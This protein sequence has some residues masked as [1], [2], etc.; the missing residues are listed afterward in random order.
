MGDVGDALVASRVPFGHGPGAA[1][2]TGAP[3]VRDVEPWSASAVRRHGARGRTPAPGRRRPRPRRPA[4]QR[5]R[6]LGRFV[7]GLSSAAARHLR[8]SALS[9]GK[10]RDGMAHRRPRLDPDSSVPRRLRRWRIKPTLRTIHGRTARDGELAPMEVAW[11]TETGWPSRLN[12]RH[13][14]SALVRKSARY[15][16]GITGDPV[17]RAHQY[18]REYDEMVVVYKTTS[19]DNARAAE[20]DLIRFNWHHVDNLRHGGGGPLA[21]PPYFLYVVRA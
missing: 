1:S 5:G 18:G 2:R 21:G 17:A 16:I 4:T 6:L 19:D 20:R 11:R 12:L 8:V 9:R 10:H 3:C 7:W 15:K 14:V 13:R